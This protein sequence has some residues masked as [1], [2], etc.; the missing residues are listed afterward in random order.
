MTV[1]DILIGPNFTETLGVPLLMGRDIGLQDTPASPRVAVVNQSF[2]Q[3]FFPNQNP[4]GR[5]LTFEEDSDK[6]DF[7]IVGVIGDSKY[8]SAKEKADRT[9]YRPILQVQDQQTFANVFELRTV[10]DPLNL[11][12]RSA[13]R[14]RAGERQASDPEYHHLRVQT[15][16]A[17]KQEKLI[18]QLVSFFGL[19]GLLLSCVGL[20]GIMAHAVVRRTNEIGIRMALGAERRDIVWMVLKESLLLVAIGSGG[21][22]TGG[23][24]R[25]APDLESTFRPESE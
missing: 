9:V 4:I 13:R 16:E 7:E 5:R 20:Y 22:H 15:D 1:A 6:D 14:H 25:G 21:R 24:G 23:V 10:G 2:A 8:D 19:L 11:A 18:A 3:S 12:G 17:L